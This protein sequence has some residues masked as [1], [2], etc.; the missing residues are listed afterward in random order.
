ML[1]LA[2][3]MPTLSYS[4]SYLRQCLAQNQWPINICWVDE[5]KL[6]IIRDACVSVGQLATPQWWGSWELCRKGGEGVG[7]GWRI[8]R[9]PSETLSLCCPSQ[10]SRGH[11][12][13]S[14]CLHCSLRP[15]QSR[16]G[17][18]IELDKSL[19]RDLAVPN[20]SSQRTRP[21]L[22]R[23]RMRTFI[24]VIEHNEPRATERCL[25]RY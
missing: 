7:W 2:E 23:Q 15:V 1:G 9:V 13:A 19:T 12:R 20:N 18:I 3:T 22:N 6:P 14:C 8:L 17:T 4:A 24:K 10:R 25:T 21:R 16:S 5:W 11:L